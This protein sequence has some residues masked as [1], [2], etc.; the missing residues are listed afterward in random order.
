MVKGVPFNQEIELSVVTPLMQTLQW[1][2]LGG[3]AG[4]GRR[5]RGALHEGAV[6]NGRR[7]GDGARGLGA[8]ARCDHRAR[9]AWRWTGI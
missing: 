9:G 1:I 7:A 2:G 8:G 5:P 3:S 6:D 4:S